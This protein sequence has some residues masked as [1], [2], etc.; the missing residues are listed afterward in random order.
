MCIYPKFIITAIILHVSYGI[1][2]WAVAEGGNIN[3][4][5]AG[6]IMPL[7]LW[8]TIICYALALLTSWL[9]DGFAS[10]RTALII[11]VIGAPIVHAFFVGSVIITAIV[12]VLF[13]FLLSILL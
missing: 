3:H 6:I 5:M 2:S 7:L 1:T 10:F 12:V 8:A 4:E 13:A 9:D 11:C